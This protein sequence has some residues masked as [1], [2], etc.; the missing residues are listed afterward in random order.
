ML[1]TILFNISGDILLKEVLLTSSNNKFN[2]LVK[3]T[4]EVI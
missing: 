3:Q 1:F 2:K 4:W